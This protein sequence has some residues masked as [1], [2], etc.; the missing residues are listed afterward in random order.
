M[1]IAIVPWTKSL[2]G[3]G[4]F[5]LNSSD[6]RDNC[7]IIYTM[8]KD[9]VEKKGGELHTIDTY[10]SLGEPDCFVFFTFNS[11]WYN[12]ILKRGLENKAV[13]M[14]M[15][16]PV[17]DDNHSREGLDRLGKLFNTVFTWDDDLCN[18][19]N[20]KM[21]YPYYAPKQWGEVPFSSKKLL[22]NISG[23]KK[24]NHSKELYSER[25][26]VI[27]YYQNDNNFE[28]YGPNWKKE[29]LAC[30]KGLAD[31]KADVYHR[32]KFAL[33]LENM[34]DVKGYVTEK[35]LDCFASGIVPVY[36]G[37]SNITEYIPADCFV[38]YSKFKSID[39]MDNYL[40]NMSEEEYNRHLAAID[41]YISKEADS[42]FMPDKFMDRIIENASMGFSHGSN[43]RCTGIAKIKFLF[44]YNVLV[45][46]KNIVK[47]LIKKK[48]C[49]TKL[50]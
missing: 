9:Y 43:F 22:V 7:M 1:K 40:R 8:M 25:R 3:D 38:D 35:I 12:E 48:T 26:R 16:P 50:R 13:Y 24:S 4:L 11:Y 39:E 41:T 10:V 30:Y 17:V 42:V 18:S 28:L 2:F 19:V 32:F 36:Q 45:K 14:A 27:D 37:A 33:C 49:T 46:C 20:K 34:K 44:W 5:D 23:N 47:R 21:M 15:E 6:N 31:S 29:N